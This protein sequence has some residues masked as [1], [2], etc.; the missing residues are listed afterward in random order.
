MDYSH[1][2]ASLILAAMSRDQP[3]IPQPQDPLVIS[4]DED[5]TPGALLEAEAD[6][7]TGRKRRSP[8]SPPPP[9]TRRCRRDLQLRTNFS[10]VNF[11]VFTSQC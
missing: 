9:C 10:F 2:S 1:L 8:S 6:P 7:N 11:T 3:R 4:S 5:E